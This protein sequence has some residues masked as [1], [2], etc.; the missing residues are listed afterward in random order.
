MEANK[1]RY[2]YENTRAVYVDGSTARR[3]NPAPD[4]RRE[5]ERQAPSRRKQV[6]HQ[7]KAFSGVNFASLLVLTCAIIVTVYVCVD[8]L[9]LQT[10]VSQT[11]K[12]IIKMEQE[13]KRLSDENAAAFEAIDSAVDLEYV[14]KVAVEKLGMVYPNNNEIIT[15][16]SGF[17]NYVRQYEDIP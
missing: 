13:I 8:Y 16:K 2:Q 5:E 14:Y 11:E 4:I 15:Y 9:M 7:P 10:Q 17:N 12:N 3:L 6:H 1:K